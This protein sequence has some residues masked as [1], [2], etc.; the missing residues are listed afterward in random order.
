MLFVFSILFTF[1]YCSYNSFIYKKINERNYINK[2]FILNK[3]LFNWSIDVEEKYIS[4]N[5]NKI[6]AMFNHPNILDGFFVLKYLLNKY[7][8]HK[9]IFVVKKD[10]IKLKIIGDF[11]KNNF[12]CL[13]RKLEKDK[14]YIEE[15]L[16]YFINKYPKI[17]VAIF[18]EGTTFCKETILKSNNWCDKNNI[19]HFN[20]LLSPRKSGIDII[21]Q[22]LKPDI[23]TNNIMYYMDD[24]YR[25][26]TVYE[27]DIFKFNIVN[28]CKII[29]NKVDI[30]K[31]NINGIYNIWRDNDK[32][33]SEE[34]K[35]LN[36]IY[37]TINKYYYLSNNL[38]KKNELMFQTTKIFLLLIP[39]TIYL[40]G[41]IYS[42][43]VLIVCLTS[44]LYHRYGKYRYVDM[45]FTSLLILHSYYYIEYNVS[46]IFMSSGIVCY[47]LS[48]FF[49]YYVSN[50]L[51]ILF[52]NLLH[53]LCGF[54]IIMELIMEFISK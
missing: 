12:L 31:Y 44:L 53:I 25:N 33:L 16:N 32:I 21:K 48:L 39:F 2:L 42:I 45:F 43:N 17:V 4:K 54:H 3:Y 11:I 37:N 20:N 38:I 5:E 47:F 24:L 10:L 46:F 50:D 22:I 40:N 34:Y 36:N 8:E 23:I 28:S 49:D 1:V 51:S 7:P 26:K 30:D 15:R 19:K 27:K 6:L 13:E 41:F 14:P 35:K 18:P 29:S 52:H 9:I